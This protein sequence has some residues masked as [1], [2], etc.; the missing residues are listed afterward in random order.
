MTEIFKSLLNE[1]QFTNEILV[2]G[3]YEIQKANYAK[4]GAYFQAFTSLATGLERIGKLCIILD[5]YI[6]NKGDFPSF[7]YM[8]HQVGHDLTMLY[9]ESKEIITRH[10]ISLKYLSDLDLKIHSSII[11]ILS[12]FAKGDR[13]SNIDFITTQNK[14][15]DPIK[16]WFQQ[17]DCLLYFGKVSKKKQMTIEHNAQMIDKTM[18]QIDHLSIY[19]NEVGQQMTNGEA[20]FMTGMNQ[21]ILKYRRLYIFHVIRYWVE[22]L[23][24]LQYKAMSSALPKHNIPFFSEI[25][26]CFFNNDKYILDYKKFDR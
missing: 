2:S 26:A 24:S 19:L 3:V 20:S 16:E 22:I 9:K 14:A 12:S 10:N 11:E 18:V 5:Y 25:F 7:R 15:S 4:K 1:A 17:I 13:Y 6:E 21:A 8:K 23:I